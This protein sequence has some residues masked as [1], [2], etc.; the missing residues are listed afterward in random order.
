MMIMVTVTMMRT[1]TRKEKGK[2]LK[3]NSE[4]VKHPPLIYITSITLYIVS[5][6][7]YIQLINNCM[8]VCIYIYTKLLYM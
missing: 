1:R 7:K 5:K 8:C 2:T 3:E 6:V 4:S